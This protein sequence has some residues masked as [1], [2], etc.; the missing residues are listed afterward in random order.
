MAKRF[1][2]NFIWLQISGSS[3]LCHTTSQ[4]FSTLP[5]KSCNR[6]YICRYT[7]PECPGY[8]RY[9]TAAVKKTQDKNSL[10]KLEAKLSSV[11]TK[12]IQH[13]HG[14]AAVPGGFY[15][16]LL[17]HVVLHSVCFQLAGWRKRA[18]QGM[19]SKWHDAID[20]NLVIGAH[21]AIRIAW[22]LAFILNILC[23]WLKS[24]TKEA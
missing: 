15:S 22:K 16:P 1:C 6:S 5:P 19:L 20:Q 14:S 23:G 13:W 12:A 2:V 11:Q 7:A 21:I 8:L 17:I 9:M 24:S 4:T 3:W 18:G 10:Y